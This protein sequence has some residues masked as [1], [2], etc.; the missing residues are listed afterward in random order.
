MGVKKIRVKKWLEYGLYPSRIRIQAF[1]GHFAPS[2]RKNE[3]QA[4]QFVV[5]HCF[6]VRWKGLI[7]AYPTVGETSKPEHLEPI[8]SHFKCSGCSVIGFVIEKN[9]DKKISLFGNSA[10]SNVMRPTPS[11]QILTFDPPFDATG[12]GL[13]SAL[14]ISFD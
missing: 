10:I 4:I 9:V 2:F 7:L 12:S 13:A 6:K 11:G 3:S 14:W 5:R 1:C 8:S